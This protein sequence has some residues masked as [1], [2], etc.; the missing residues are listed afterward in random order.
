MDD[1]THLQPTVRNW[2]EL[3]DEERIF[4]M[5]R[6]LWIGY[7]QAIKILGQM[8]DLLKHPRISRM[9]NLLIVGKTNSGKSQILERFKSLHPASDN[10]G[11]EAI[12]VPVLYVEAPTMPDEKR[13]YIEILDELFAK[14][15]FSDSAAKLFVNVREKFERVGVRMLLIDELNNLVTGSMAKQRHFLTVLKYLSN[16]LQIPLVCAGTEEAVRALQTDPQLS[17]RFV[18]VTLPRWSMDADYRRFLASWE[19]ILPLRL[20]SGLS[21]KALAHEILSKSGGT[22]GEVVTLLKKAAS[23]A[24]ASKRERIDMHAIE[25]CDYIGPGGS[26]PRLIEV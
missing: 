1:L 19:K 16:Q 2:L 21:E 11:G 8:E 3:T 5:K 10:L 9:P 20:P 6:D 22:T 4:E 24:I 26:K 14:Y 25:H 18:P 23:Y 17:N 13:F 12:S 7:P 15:S